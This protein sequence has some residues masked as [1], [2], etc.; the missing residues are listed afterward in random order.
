[1]TFTLSPSS[2]SRGLFAKRHMRMNPRFIN[3]SARAG[4]P[5]DQLRDQFA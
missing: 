4:E 3:S 2:T 1:V 5:G